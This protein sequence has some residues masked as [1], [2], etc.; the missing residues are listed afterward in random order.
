[1]VLLLNYLPWIIACIG[2]YSIWRVMNR[3]PRDKQFKP[4]VVRLIIT[5]VA[6][7]LLQGLT[8]GYI[9]KNPSSSVGIGMP[10]FE[11][12]DAEIANHLRSPQRLGEESEKRFND[13][14][15]W[16]KTPEAE[17]PE[18]VEPVTPAP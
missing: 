18:V 17:K 7:L 14:T 3:V 8:A 1:M 13:K 10:E 15:D 5:V 12:S 11:Q 9:P 2:V 6:I 4:V 16:R